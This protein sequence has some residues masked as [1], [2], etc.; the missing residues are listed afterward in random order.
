MKGLR[1]AVLFRA[2]ANFDS[3]IALAARWRSLAAI[4]AAAANCFNRA[5]HHKRAFAGCY[6]QF[7][8]TSRILLACQSVFGEQ[9]AVAFRST[10]RIFH[11][12]LTA[13][14]DQASLATTFAAATPARRSAAERPA[15]RSESSRA[16]RDIEPHIGI[17][18]NDEVSPFAHRFAS[19]PDRISLMYPCTRL[20]EAL[21]A[22]PTWALSVKS[23]TLPAWIN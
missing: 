6:N 2:A 1:S 11:R 23:S 9:F 7:Q 16:R 5:Q 8:L 17:V 13:A 3:G 22:L 15:T 21:C 20:T 18:D 4:E 12:H 19:R 10:R 14:T